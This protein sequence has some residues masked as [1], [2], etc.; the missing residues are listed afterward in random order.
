MRI[1]FVCTGNIMRSV[2]AECVARKYLTEMLREKADVISVESAGLK[3]TSFEPPHPECISAL[4]KL[5]I[6]ECDVSSKPI[7]EEAVNSADIV[8]AMTREQ[9]YQVASEFRGHSSRCFSLIGLNG[10]IDSLLDGERTNV[11]SSEL[12]REEIEK[13]LQTATRAIISASKKDSRAIP[14]VPLTSRE[15]M[16]LFP[17]CFREVS[18]ISDPL[19]GTKDE[20]EM[21]ARKI[22]KE[23]GLMLDGMF[24]V[25]LKSFSR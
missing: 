16:T 10:L 17:V 5:G 4:Q 20:V 19:P 8:I 25:G 11:D 6:E 9:C 15:L 2:I 22:E 21:C 7:T 1:L 18:N 12:S 24:A 14:G 13:V 3:A 23:V